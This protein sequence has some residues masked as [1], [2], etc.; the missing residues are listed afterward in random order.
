MAVAPGCTARYL[1][2]L[3]SAEALSLAN[4][5]LAAVGVGLS[6]S[7]TGRAMAEILHSVDLDGE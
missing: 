3:K 5:I 6:T 2:L 7:K 4:L 1:A